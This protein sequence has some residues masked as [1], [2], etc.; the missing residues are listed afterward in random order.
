M[1]LCSVRTRAG[2]PGDADQ[3]IGRSLSVDCSIDSAADS[4]SSSAQSV[5][6]FAIDVPGHHVEE[7]VAFGRRAGSAVHG[8]TA[9]PSDGRRRTRQPSGA[10]RWWRRRMSDAG[11]HRVR[12]G[13]R[14]LVG[15][16]RDRA[17]S[18][19]D[20]LH[21]GAPEAVR[22]ATGATTDGEE[23]GIEVDDGSEQLVGAIAGS[24]H[25]AHD[26]SARRRRRHPARRDHVG[27]R[28]RTPVC[29]RPPRACTACTTSLG[30]AV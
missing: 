22:Q 10:P 29:H 21:R 17:T 9:V 5:A 4:R 1:V 12:R 23:L 6:M 16:D 26:R 28:T 11:H 30:P 3:V 18:A 7:S 8:S 19:F 15:D 13:R 27:P 2:D 25:G 14:D 20:E 24:H